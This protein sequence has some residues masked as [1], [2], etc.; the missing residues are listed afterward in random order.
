MTSYKPHEDYSSWNYDS[1]FL[2]NFN[3]WNILLKVNDAT[4]NRANTTETIITNQ[5]HQDYY[6]R[7]DQQYIACKYNGGL[8][9]VTLELVPDIILKEEED[10]FHQ[11]A[12]QYDQW[13]NTLCTPVNED[14]VRGSNTFNADNHVFNI[15]KIK[16]DG[17]S[18]T[19]AV[20]EL[21]ESSNKSNFYIDKRKSRDV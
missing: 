17:T 6:N 1:D 5:K 16:S 9:Q 14:D 18:K 4:N 12:D 15:T 13:D 2:D 19:R 7:R 21:S 3:N 10:S 11:W 8:E 20:S